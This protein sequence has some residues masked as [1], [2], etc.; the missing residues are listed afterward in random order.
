[1]TLLLGKNQQS[2][3]LKQVECSFGNTAEITSDE[4]PQFFTLLLEKIEKIEF[5]S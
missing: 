3:P 5:F 1:M 2:V 4:R